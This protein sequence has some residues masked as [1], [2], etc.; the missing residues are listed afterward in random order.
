MIEVWKPK[1]RSMLEHRFLSEWPNLGKFLAKVGE[2]YYL[3]G[4]AKGKA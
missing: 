2:V 1:S 4:I 3:L